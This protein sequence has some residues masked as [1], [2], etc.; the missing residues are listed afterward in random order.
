MFEKV[1]IFNA[2]LYSVWCFYFSRQVLE[3]RISPLKTYLLILLTHVAIII[4]GRRMFPNGVPF[5]LV[6]LASILSIALF[7][8]GT[9][10][11]KLLTYFLYTCTVMLMEML[12]IC[13]YVNVQRIFF[14]KAKSFISMNSITSP[15][16]LIIM[17][18]IILT[19]GTPMCKLLADLTGTF[20]KFYNIVPLAQIFFPFYWFCIILSMCCN[21]QIKFNFY[22]LVILALSVPVIPV[23]LRGIRNIHVQ[24][25]NRILR[26]KQ[27][28]LLKEQLDFFN[29]METEYQNLRKW[30]H[31]IENHLLSM[32]YLMQN[33]KY[34]EA[35]RYLHNIS[36]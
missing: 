2:L 21:Y 8:Y 20:T 4:G 10:K 15:V 22:F 9:I 12:I 27:I 18:C 31:D 33:E 29:D 5:I 23:F 7:H 26:E 17:C 19:A 32:N 28:E 25:K 34:E 1:F 11:K 3:E 6:H 36:R 16:D 35:D 14:H 30:N 24:E 13:L